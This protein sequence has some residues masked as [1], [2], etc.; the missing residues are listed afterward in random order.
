MKKISTLLAF[1]PALAIGQSLVYNTPQ[2]RT[3][4]LE[5]FTGIHCG[6]CP[7]GHVI[8]ASLGSVLGDRFVTVGVHAGGYAVPGVGEPDFRTEDGTAID[9]HFTI[10]G[11]PAGVINRHLF[12]G[13]D[14]LGRGAWEGAVNEVLAMPSPVNVGME[15]SFD[16]TNLTVHVVALY[17]GDSPAGNDYISVFV[18]ENH[19]TGP[20]VDYLNGNHTDYD[21]MHVLRGYLTDTWGEDVGN[22]V[23]GDLVERTYTIPVPPEWVIANCEVSAFVSEY[24]SEVYQARNV[25]ADGGTTL[26]VGD[27]QGDTQPY[28]SGS[29]GTLTPF[30]GS[31]T[32]QLGVDE[33][34][35]ITLTSYGSPLTWQSSFTVDGNTPGNPATVTVAN[36]ATVALNVEIT[37]DGTPGIGTFTLT[38]ASATNTSAPVLEQ[39][40]H[41]IS[42]VHDLVVTNPQA[43]AHE[44]IYIDGMVAEYNKAATTRADFIEFGN[45][46]ALADV[47]NL[48]LNISWTFPSYNDD[49]AN[50]LSAFMDNGGNLMIAGQDIGWDQSG[51]T[52]SYGTPVTQAFYTNYLHSTFVADGAAA[53]NQV[54][55]ED[56][57]AVFGTVANTTIIDAFGGFTYPDQI[58]PIAPAVPIMRYSAAKIGGLRAQTTNYKVVYFGIGPEQVASDEIAQ[59]MVGLSHDWFYGVVSVEEFDAA[60]NALGNAYPSPANTEVHI[61]VGTLNGAATLEV[62]DATGRIVI[63]QSVNSTGSI[64]TLNT[65]PLNSGLYS[66]RLRSTEG[67]SVARTFQVA[68]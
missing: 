20:Q 62:F 44:P 58:T 18:E 37:P 1:A 49:V 8:M 7:E 55:F 10:S 27:L 31:F 5:D 66:A 53:D 26:V 13:L 28:R 50:V 3:A 9:A 12:G 60:M 32:N 2:N 67:N 35:V 34:Y 29:D 25:A 45:A 23:A 63:S 61:P 33:Q 17:T 57:D 52:G 68:H 22:H 64:I 21:H 19:I 46:N 11:Y 65:A 15:S 39:R 38:I 59:L 4:L 48:Y 36:G 16:G 6:Y 51:A 43:E 30:N 41:I 40:Y 42:G 47:N 56:G 54:N 14:D 24:Q